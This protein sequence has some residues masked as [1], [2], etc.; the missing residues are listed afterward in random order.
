MLGHE[1]D[2]CLTDIVFDTVNRMARLPDRTFIVIKTWEMV[3]ASLISDS[4]VSPGLMGC[5][6]SDGVKQFCR[7]IAVP[8][9]VVTGVAIQ[10][11]YR[12]DPK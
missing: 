9:I 7:R 10:R 1:A 6:E 11:P 5:T 8:H 12:A 3:N 2:H 4:Q